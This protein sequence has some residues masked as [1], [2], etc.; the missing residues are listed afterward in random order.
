MP[1]EYKTNGNQTQG[2]H[3]THKENESVRPIVNNIQTQYYK[4]AKY[5]NK[6]LNNLVCLPY[7]YTTKSS[8]EIAQELNIIQINKHN[9]MITLDI[10]NLY[11][12]LPIENILH[13]TKFWLNKHKNENKITEQTLHLLKIILKQNFFQYNNQ[14][15]QPEKGIA[16][17]S[18][19]SN[20]IAE[21][22]LQFL[23]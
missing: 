5:F 1:Y 20:T 18:P 23:E 12:N 14:F 10:K 17:R 21:I 2:M 9:K 6:S 16:M 11:V 7:T 15:F 19:I 8:R 22:Y 13:I 3:K 4:I